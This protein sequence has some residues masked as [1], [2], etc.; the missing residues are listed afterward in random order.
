MQSI[1]LNF[2]SILKAAETAYELFKNRPDNPRAKRDCNGGYLSITETQTQRTLC[3][4][5]IGNLSAFQKARF[6]ELCLEKQRRLL[7]NKV[8]TSYSDRNPDLDKFAGALQLHESK[9][10]F[11]FS[12][13][14]DYGDECVAAYVAIK[15]GLSS[16]KEVLNICGSYNPFIESYLKDHFST[17]I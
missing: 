16:V 3:V 5:E 13:L 2:E 17:A 7:K 1:T 11:S 9:L 14:P 6:A 4:L 12:G 10:I 8:Q 15:I